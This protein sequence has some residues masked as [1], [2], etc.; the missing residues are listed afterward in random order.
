VCAAL[1]ATFGYACGKAAGQ[2]TTPLPAAGSAR[3]DGSG[4]L[5]MASSGPTLGDPNASKSYGYG[6]LGY[7]YSYD[8]G[9]TAY[10]K[11][12]G[13]SLYANYFF[14]QEYLIPAEPPKPYRPTYSHNQVTSYGSVRGVV[15]WPSAPKVPATLPAGGP[16]AGSAPNP[17]LIVDRNG[18]VANTV[19]YLADIKKGRS[20]PST[21]NNYVHQALRTGGALQR[22]ECQLE[23]HIQIVAPIG[24][25]LTVH[26]VDGGDT[27]LI[28]TRWGD[29][30][31]DR[32]FSV[33]LAGAGAV[34]ELSLDRDGWI[35]VHPFEQ[36]DLGSAWVVVADQPYYSITDDSDEFLLHRVP[37]GSY[38]LVA[39]HE[40][41]ITGI[42]KAGHAVM[43][44]P[45]GVR[46]KI[47]VRAKKTT[48]LTLKLD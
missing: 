9:S 30:S 6:G 5:A 35:R 3:D 34:E 22:K 15:L 10:G 37:P 45:K 19:V 47:T 16:C 23:P 20:H 7:A 31:N 24:K 42:D 4:I 18:R 28:G 1:A 40:P 29:K 48:R 13:G 11:G 14:Q 43:S 25:L 39:W 38:E 32:V 2:S 27:T 46:R 8:Y 26:N 33:E 44:K 36:K 12:Y 41:L 17:S 21:V